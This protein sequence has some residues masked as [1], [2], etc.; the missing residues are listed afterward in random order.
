[1]LFLNED[2]ST[3]NLPSTYIAPPEPLHEFSMNVELITSILSFSLAAPPLPS[4]A[5][6]LL[7]VKLLFTN[8]FMIALSSI[9][10]AP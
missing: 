5:V 4:L 2:P 3:F 9:T 1:M 10:I 6:A 8:E 7:L